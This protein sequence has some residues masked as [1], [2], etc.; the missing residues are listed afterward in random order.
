MKNRIGQ[1]AA[2][3]TLALLGGLVALSAC[4]TADSEEAVGEVQEAVG[5]SCSV[6][7]PCRSPEVCCSGTCRNPT[8][9]PLNCNGCGNVCPTPSNSTATCSSRVCGYTCNTAWGD[10]NANATDGC[11]TPLNTVAHCQSCTHGCGSPQHAT[12]ACAFFGG[13]Y[14]AACDPGWLDCDGYENNGCEVNKLSDNN[15]CGA[16]GHVCTGGMVCSSG[17]C[18]CPTGYTNC[19]GNCVDTTSDENNCGGCGSENPSH[20]CSQRSGYPTTDY[21][22]ACCGSLCG[23]AIQTNCCGTTGANCPSGGCTQDGNDVYHCL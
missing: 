14:V 20:I 15:N 23:T 22:V 21:P 5:Q 11:E 19:G 6:F 17:S 8:N 10:C 3:V 2:M 12:P 9:D 16:C 18:V 1:A 7:S 4:A 13:C